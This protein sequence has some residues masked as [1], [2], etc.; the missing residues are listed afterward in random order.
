MIMRQAVLIK[1]FKSV[2]IIFIFCIF[3]L[4][5]HDLSFQPISGNKKFLTFKLN[6]NNRI[7]KFEMIA[8][9][10]NAG[11]TRSFDISPDGT[12]LA[13][14][15][16]GGTIQVWNLSDLTYITEWHAHDRFVSVLEFNSDGTILASGGFDQVIRFWNIT[17]RREISNISLGLEA[18]WGLRYSPNGEYFAAGTASG[19]LNIWRI[20]DLTEA[21][22]R[23]ESYG[24]SEAA[25]ESIY[26]NSKNDMIFYIGG[27]KIHFFNLTD[28]TDYVVDPYIDFASF[29]RLSTVNEIAVNSNEDLLAWGYTKGDICVMNI[30]SKTM[31][32]IL[33]GHAKDDHYL[34]SVQGLTFN[35]NGEIL[36]SIAYDRTVK[37]W[38]MSNGIEISGTEIGNN[39]YYHGRGGGM[40]DVQ[41]TPSDRYLVIAHRNTIIIWGNPKQRDENTSDSFKTISVLTIFEI[42]LL[43]YTFYSL[44]K[45]RFH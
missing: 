16:Y 6:E 33:Q 7:T 9:W 26:F 18:I 22:Y 1:E 4:S 25:D 23:F 37:L 32:W 30:T 20:T 29:S 44:K 38:N 41:F 45:N 27:R 21:I 24:N 13:S 14:G 28:Q 15:G 39:N 11:E 12:V 3:S 8:Y 19:I 43:S 10:A 40:A 34:H 35:E 5:Y 17:E 2:I 31:K 42:G 36:I